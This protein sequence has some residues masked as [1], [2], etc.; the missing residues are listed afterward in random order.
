MTLEEVLQHTLDHHPLL[1]ARAHEVEAARGRLVTASLLPNPQW[2]MDTE[3]P[4][5]RDDA[6]RL[7][8]RLTFTLPTGRKRRWRM[9]AT[10]AGV[11]R[12]QAALA[13]ETELLLAEAADAA[14]EV[15]Y[16]QELA[17]LQGELSQL[18]ARTAEVVGGQFQGGTTPYTTTIKSRLDAAE[19]ELARLDTRGRLEQARVRLNRAAGLAPAPL[20]S[21][22]G[23]LVV[24]TIPSIRL[25]RLLAEADDD[26]GR[27]WP[28]RGPPCSR[29][30]GDIPKPVPRPGRTST[31]ARGCTTRWGSR[32]TGSGHAWPSIF[33]CSIG[34]KA[35]LRKTRRMIRTR[36]AML[37]ATEINTLSDVAAA[38][39]ELQAAQTQLDYHRTHV[40]PFVE[41]AEAAIR[42]TAADK[43][44]AP[45]Q[46]SELMEQLARMRVEQ[47]DLRYLH[48]R[49]RMRLELLL[50]RPLEDFQDAG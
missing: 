42:G 11:A 25:E 43:V 19:I 35:G 10:E 39:V 23:E 18:A 16:L 13:R 21:M 36:C 30:S 28:N 38:Y 32:T 5:A 44:L 29:V 49:L 34:I 31:S 41:Q 33:P 1:Q 6:T 40:Q 27:I 26:V 20:V 17:T 47:L 37:D 45:G 15:L 9:A 3:S 24:E 8:T 2:V 14:I 22:R 48:T 7:S 12:S 4:V 50:G 46:I